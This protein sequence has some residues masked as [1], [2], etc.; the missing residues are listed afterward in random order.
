MKILYECQNC[1]T[2]VEDTHVIVFRKIRTGGV[3]TYDTAFCS[4]ECIKIAVSAGKAS[5][6]VKHLTK[7]KNKPG[8]GINETKHET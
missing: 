4:M 2:P 5:D 7:L 6:Q 8:S 1:R 3:G